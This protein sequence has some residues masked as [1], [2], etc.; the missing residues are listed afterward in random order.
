MFGKKKEGGFSVEQNWHGKN[1]RQ[2]LL[3]AEEA[4]VAPYLPSTAEEAKNLLP[5][6]CLLPAAAALHLIWR[7]QGQ[8]RLDVCWLCLLL[9]SI[10]V[11]YA[12]HSLYVISY[13]CVYSHIYIYFIM[14]CLSY[15]VL[16]IYV[17]CTLEGRREEETTCLPSPPFLSLSALLPLIPLLSVCL[18]L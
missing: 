15:P 16:Y 5:H 13:M 10:Y 4:L 3:E 7:R 17:C 11:M 2:E 1:R 6:A 14:S 8:G 18:S 12:A 9:G